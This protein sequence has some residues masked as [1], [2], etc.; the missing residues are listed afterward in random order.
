MSDASG[1]AAEPITFF[2][3][4]SEIFDNF[5]ARAK[6]PRRSLKTSFTLRALER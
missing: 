1:G 4:S 2:F 6:S 5:L 3:G